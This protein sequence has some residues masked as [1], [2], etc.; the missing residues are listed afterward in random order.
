MGMRSRRR[1]WGVYFGK[2]SKQTECVI[3]KRLW[4]NLKPA[5]CSCSGGGVREF[6]KLVPHGGQ[7]C[8]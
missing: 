8:L 7:S 1:D 6:T 2:A 4:L 3:S 5:R